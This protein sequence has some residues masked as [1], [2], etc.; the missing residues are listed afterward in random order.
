MTDPQDVREWARATGRQVGDR[1]R[2]PP[3]LVAEYEA[4]QETPDDS[5]A[6]VVSAPV[7]TSVPDVGASEDAPAVDVTPPPR[8][9]EQPP[10]GPRRRRFGTP[11]PADEP[12][13]KKKRASL[14]TFASWVWGLGGLAL[15]QAPKSTPVGRMLALQAPVAGVIVDDLAK[16]TVVDKLLQPFA[17]SS[18]KAEKAFALLGPPLLVGA[19]SANPALFDVL[20]G[21][22]KVAMLSW[23]EISEPAMRQA[24][25]KAQA[26]A[27]R[28]GEIDVD[29]M[30]Q[31]LFADSLP[32]PEEEAAVRRARGEG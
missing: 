12:A 2:V 3:A 14:E 10:R 25:R 15:Q 28:L 29:A 26:M 5:D 19:I 13:G 17:R 21:P 27:E 1:G 31:A 30:I 22:L 18:E 23:A 6:I 16:G 8:R 24:E 32:S 9:P 20:A 11:K 4:A 7:L